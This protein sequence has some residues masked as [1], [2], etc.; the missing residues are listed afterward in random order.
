MIANKES[1]MLYKLKN[2]TC[3]L[4]KCRFCKIK[5]V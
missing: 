4:N 2:D 1:K 5:Y 3:I